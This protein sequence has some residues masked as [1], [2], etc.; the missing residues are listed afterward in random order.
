MKEYTI[1]NTDR[2][3]FLILWQQTLASI[4]YCKQ[5]LMQVF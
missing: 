1:Y 5:L 3:V 4:I 2:M